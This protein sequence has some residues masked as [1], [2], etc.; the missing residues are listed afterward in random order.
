M[1]IDGSSAIVVGGASGLG[2]DRLLTDPEGLFA[3]SLSSRNG[4]G[5]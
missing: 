1:R 3:L 4:I 2:L 5:P